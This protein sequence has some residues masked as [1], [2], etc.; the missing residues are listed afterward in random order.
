M[1]ENL[2]LTLESTNQLIKN[3]VFWMLIVWGAR[4]V[5]GM[6]RASMKQKDITLEKA[7][8]AFSKD[9]KENSLEIAKL[10]NTL[11]VLQTKFEPLE[12]FSYALPKIQQDLNSLWDRVRNGPR[13]EA[14]EN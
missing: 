3:P 8:E 6:I 9:L 11:I 4:E 12:K 14:K 13:L 7:H 10:N 2:D 5:F 1:T